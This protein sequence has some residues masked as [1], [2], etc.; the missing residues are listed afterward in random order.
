MASGVV[1]NSQKLI[2]S[3]FKHR[4]TNEVL[5]IRKKKER[6]DW[7]RKWLG[8]GPDPD[9]R[10]RKS[11]RHTGQVEWSWNDSNTAVTEGRPF[12]SGPKYREKT[13]AR[14]SKHDFPNTPSNF[15]K[16]LDFVPHSNV[17]ITKSNVTLF[18][19]IY[20]YIYILSDDIFAKKPKQFLQVSRAQ[21]PSASILDCWSTGQAIDPV[22]G[23]I[24]YINKIHL[25]SQGCPRPSITLQCEFV[26]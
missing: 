16:L 8:P 9:Q 22:P 3:F 23:M 4:N 12:I 21:G 15:F 24:H 18:G 13:L 5:K 11:F 20:I 7:I 6:D 25:I 10:R 2:V 14:F 19:T 26:A 1:R 17:K